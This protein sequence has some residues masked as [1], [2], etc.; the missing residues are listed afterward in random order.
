MEAEFLA[1]WQSGGKPRAVQTLRANW[2]LAGFATRLEG[3]RF[4]A[5]FHFDFK[6]SSNSAS[7]AGEPIS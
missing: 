2:M 4:S 5:A 1:A 7:P 6:S 3:G